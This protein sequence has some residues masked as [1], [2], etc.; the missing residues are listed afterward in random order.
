MPQNE[1]PPI[2]ADQKC[3][4][5]VSQKSDKTVV[6]VIQV[7]PGGWDYMKDG[8]SHTFDLTKVGIPIQIILAGCKS[9]AD[10]RAVLEQANA[11]KGVPALHMPGTDFGIKK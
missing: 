8:Q 2:R 11:Q 4:F 10:G 3:V 7:P 9:V 5:G 1:K 6:A